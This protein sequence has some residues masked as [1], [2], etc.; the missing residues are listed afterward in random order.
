MKLIITRHGETVENK[1]HIIMGQLPGHLNRLG[2]QQA[3]KVAKR[4]KNEEIDYIYS[5]DLARAANTAKEIR[6]YHKN[7]P[8]KFVKDLREK[9]CG[10]YEGTSTKIMHSDW[11][12]HAET[13]KHIYYRVKKFLDKTL[14]KHKTERVLF[15]T[16]G[17][18]IRAL[19]RIIRNKSWNNMYKDKNAGNTSITIATINEN[20]KHRIHLLGCMKHLE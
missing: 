14:H 19:M 10:K 13:D 7:V 15:V 1:N 20:K 16:H 2:I 12:K 17:G 8:I 4:L 5:S 6:K 18:T 9:Y 11:N 3:K